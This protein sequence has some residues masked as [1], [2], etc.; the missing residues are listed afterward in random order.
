[1]ETIYRVCLFYWL[2][3]AS[4]QYFRNDLGMVDAMGGLF[5]G[6]WIVF[7][8]GVLLFAYIF[9]GNEKRLKLI[10]KIAGIPCVLTG[11]FVLITLLSGLVA[12]G[13]HFL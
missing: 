9:R 3:I 1:M 4:F 12:L 5:Y 7:F 8:I 13:R 2:A 10:N 6:L 11:V